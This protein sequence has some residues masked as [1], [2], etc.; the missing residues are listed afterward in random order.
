MPNPRCDFELG[1]CVKYYDDFDDTW[2]EGS[3]EEVIPHDKS[4]EGA[5]MCWYMVKFDNG[6]KGCFSSCNAFLVCDAMDPEYFRKH[7]QPLIDFD[8]LYW[9]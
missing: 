5:P 8:D 1:E 7:V 3:I 4:T 9:A 6:S 2:Q